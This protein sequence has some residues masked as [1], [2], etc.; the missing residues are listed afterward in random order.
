MAKARRG[1]GEG[2][3]YRRADGY[4]VA[5]VDAGRCP[6]GH[7]KR[8]GTICKGGEPVRPPRPPPQAHRRRAQRAEG[9]RR[10][11]DRRPRLD[12]PQVDRVVARQRQGERVS[13]QTLAD[14]RR[15]AEH[16]I[17]PHIGHIRL[18][19][20]T[21]PDVQAMMNA[22]EH[23]GQSRRDG[24]G[25]GPKARNAARTL[26]S[27]A[28]KH[29]KGL[30]LISDNPADYVNGA[31]VGTRLDDTEV[32]AVLDAARDDRLYAL[33]HVTV[34][35]G[36]REGEMLALKRTEIDLDDKGEFRVDDAKSPGWRAD[37]PLRGRHPARDEGAHGPPG[38]RAP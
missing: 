4:W 5:Q 25:H 32:D 3:L 26:L 29:A 37:A 27:S 10:R 24:K 15:W 20:L 33:L 35:L 38:R 18:R 8:N 19:K 16:R 1:R 11:R 21:P 23:S 34:T 9:T 31:K 2:S 30:K 17:Y 12:G 14:Y 7:E 6:G 28:L 22:L 13:E 36:N